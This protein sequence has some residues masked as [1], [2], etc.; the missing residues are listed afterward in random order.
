[1]TNSRR[2]I[3]KLEDF[4]GLKLRVLQSPLFIELV[5]A[6]GANAVPMPFPEVYTAL[7]QKVIDGQENP[8]TVILDSKFQEVQK[9]VSITR[10]IY[11]PQSV[12]ISKRTWDKLSAD[13]KKI[14]Q[15][16]ADEAKIYQ[17]QVSRQKA[18]EALEGLKKGGMQANE[19]TPQEMTRIREKAKPVIDKYAKEVGEDLYK[20]VSA[21]I[22][23]KRGVN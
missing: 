17:R 12:L 20:E 18:D 1:M 6:L 2:P 5:N 15:E 10:H 21:E 9:Y 8:L 23:K 19:I 13:E 3:A 16:A 14:I 7:E 4:Q 22:A 11:N